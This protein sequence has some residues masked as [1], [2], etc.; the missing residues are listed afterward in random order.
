MNKV[1]ITQPA[2]KATIRSAEGILSVSVG[3]AHALQPN[4]A[5][6]YQVDGKTLYSGSATSHTFH[7]IYRGTHTVTVQLTDASG[8]PVSSASATVYMKRPFK[9]K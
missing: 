8:N 4:Q 5:L 6:V 9:K 7:N 3:L 2:D 1:S